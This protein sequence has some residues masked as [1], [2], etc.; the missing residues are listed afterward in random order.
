MR[1]MGD[2]QTR[3]ALL[4]PVALAA[5]ATLLVN[6]HVLKA[7]W[8]GWWTGKL[9][10]LAALIVGPIAVAAVWQGVARRLPNTLPDWVPRRVSA[11]GAI[12]LGFGVAFA[13][14]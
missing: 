10:D 13:A 4:H 3:A 9:S 7:A 8:P 5:L 12:A 11:E 1:A 14:V 2:R 6:D